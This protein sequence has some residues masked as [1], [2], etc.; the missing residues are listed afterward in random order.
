MEKKIKSYQGEKQRSDWQNKLQ[1]VMQ[2]YEGWN[3]QAGWA[4]LGSSKYN[5]AIL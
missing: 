5:Q 3:S 1:N 2:L 4:R